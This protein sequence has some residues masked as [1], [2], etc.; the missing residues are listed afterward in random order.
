MEI[1]HHHQRRTY[2]GTS[3]P[4]RADG[5]DQETIRRGA[6]VRMVTRMVG[7]KL[8]RPCRDAETREASLQ[9]LRAARPTL[10][11]FTPA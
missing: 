6:L 9:G 2:H 7:R 5:S 8:P 3:E 4:L 11:I 1:G 10:T